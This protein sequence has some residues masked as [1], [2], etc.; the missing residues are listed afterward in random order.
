MIRGT[1][2]ML[3][4]LLTTP[5]QA[6]PC[7]MIRQAVATYGEAAVEAW[8]RSKNMTEREIERARKCLK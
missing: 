3:A 7:W 5:A 8:A 1:A 2:L 4:L 6:Y